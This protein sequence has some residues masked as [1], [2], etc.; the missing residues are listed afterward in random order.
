MLWNTVPAGATHRAACQFILFPIRILVVGC[1]AISQHCHYVGELRARTVVLVGIEED[2][3]T[4]KVVH[5]AEDGA[6]Q[7]T[8]FGNPYCHAIA[9][10]VALAFN[11]E[12][13]FQLCSD[14]ARLDF[15]WPQVRFTCQFVAVNG[16]LEKIHPACEGR[17]EASRTYLYGVVC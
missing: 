15:S 5:R 9:M 1:L 7:R 13:D 16:N 17:S 12:L 6:S 4:F 2:P 11:L 8:L 14:S 3:E 10:E